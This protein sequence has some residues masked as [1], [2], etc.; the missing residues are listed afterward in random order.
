MGES[1]EP[2]HDKV[3]RRHEHIT[4]EGTSRLQRM[5]PSAETVECSGAGS[6][7]SAAEPLQS[8]DS[9][10]VEVAHLRAAAHDAPATAPEAIDLAVPDD[11]CVICFAELDSAE[12]QRRLEC[13]HVFHTSCVGEWIAKDGRCPVCR[14]VIDA[15]VANRAQVLALP[16][17]HGPSLSEL[18]SSHLG[19]LGLP[20]RP[21]TLRG[22]PLHIADAILLQ[23]SRRLMVFATVE[24]ALSVLVMSY[25]PDDLLSPALMLL[26]ACVTFSGA[27]NFSLRAVAICRPVLGLNIIYH[28]YL[29]ARI[30][31]RN[32]GPSFFDQA[33]ASAKTVLLSLGCVVVMELLALKKAGLFYLKLRLRSPIELERLRAFRRAQ[34]G[35]VQRFIVVVAFLL[36]CAP[37]CKRYICS[38]GV[39][40]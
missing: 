30:V 13:G 40:D 18:G 21:S 22:D 9:T 37:V 27:N 20:G 5:W 1:H 23:L 7:S 24:A 36:I 16:P 15:L 33:P 10:V 25:I 14:H 31:H 12:Q 4:S 8:S 3:P 29:I 2:A 11:E 6:S 34:V 39:C 26:S 17:S 35:C 38:L 28:L 32:D 19:E